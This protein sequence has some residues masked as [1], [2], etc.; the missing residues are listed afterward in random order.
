MY[1]NDDIKNLALFYTVTNHMFSN[2]SVQHC[3]E[4]QNI[5]NNTAY[6]HISHPQATNQYRRVRDRLHHT[7]LNTA[8]ERKT[9]EAGIAIHFNNNLM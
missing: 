5:S 6:H 3:H 7:E 2:M 1:I 4:Q 9:R 8:G